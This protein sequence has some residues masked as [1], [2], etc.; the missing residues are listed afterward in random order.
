MAVWKR[1]V[2]QECGKQ[3]QDEN[4]PKKWAESPPPCGRCGGTTRYSKQWYVSLVLDGQKYVKA[5]SLTKKGAEEHEA[6]LVSSRANGE[7]VFTLKPLPFPEAV[8][9]FL[10]WAEHRCKIGMLSP[11]TLETYRSRVANLLP[12]FKRFDLKQIDHLEAD[13]YRDARI[14]AGVAFATINKELGALCH[15]MGV[16]KQ[17]KLIRENNMDDYEY[18]PKTS[19]KTRFLS[20]EEIAVLLEKC[21]ESRRPKYLYPIVVVALETGLRREGVVGLEWQHISFARKEITRVV[22][23]GKQITIPMTSRLVKVLQDWRARSQKVVPI[24]GWETL[25][26][27]VFPSPVTGGVMHRGTNLG[28]EPVIEACGWDDVTFHTLRHTFATHF[29]A[30]TKNIH[31][32]AD[33]LGHSTVVITQIYSHVIDETKAHA[34]AAYEQA[35]GSQ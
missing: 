3:H 20:R 10:G 1:R 8:K 35:M 30:A 9:V 25:T 24:G 34:M 5:V 2:C 33:I 11:R 16:C 31:L 28:Y 22:K 12:A 27:P 15:I 17:K 4:V 29:L 32:L 18:L 23:G 7:K 26:G 21:R 13:S 6:D 19:R 14:E